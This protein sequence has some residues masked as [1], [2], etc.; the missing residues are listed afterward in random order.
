MLFMCDTFTHTETYDGK[1]ANIRRSEPKGA[2]LKKLKAGHSWNPTQTSIQ[3]EGK[4]TNAIQLGH[5][6]VSAEVSQND[7][8]YDSARGPQIAGSLL[9]GNLREWVSEW[10]RNWAR[11]SVPHNTTYVHTWGGK[12]GSFKN[13]TQCWEGKTVN[14]F[15]HAMYEQEREGPFHNPRP[16]WPAKGELFKNTTAALC[17]WEKG[18]NMVE[19]NRYARHKEESYRCCTRSPKFQKNKKPFRHKLLSIT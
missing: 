9:D 16:A 7:F 4:I 5:L 11:E 10:G 14:R 6:K 3:Q 1:R 15:K 8:K 13:Q 12:D 2:T 17:K 19:H 18:E